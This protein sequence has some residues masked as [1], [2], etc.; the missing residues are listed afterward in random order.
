LRS[1]VVFA[2]AVFAIDALAPQLFFAI[3]RPRETN[4]F[5][6]H[7]LQLEF[8]PLLQGLLM[9]GL[10]Y[11]LF[12]LAI[13]I[14]A[15]RRG[16]LGVTPLLVAFAGWL[17]AAITT[18]RWDWAS[19]TRRSCWAPVLHGDRGPFGR[20]GAQLVRRW[21]IRATPAAHDWPDAP[22][23]CAR[24]TY[25]WRAAAARRSARWPRRRHEINSLAYVKREPQSACALWEGIAP[26]K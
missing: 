22:M 9:L 23:R 10:V 2:A 12:P 24:S 7:F 18:P 19:T 1:A 14:R 26:T 5:G 25:D 6:L 8:T 4:V 11:F 3:D 16:E 15:R 21:T 17:V 20:A 13:C